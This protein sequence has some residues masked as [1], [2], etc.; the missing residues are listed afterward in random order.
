MLCKGNAFRQARRQGCITAAQQP[1]AHVLLAFCAA[2][3][4]TSRGKHRPL[5]CK[6]HLVSQ[7]L[8]NMQL[9]LG[10]LLYQWSQPWACIRA[11]QGAQHP[12]KAWMQQSPACMQVAGKR[13]G[14]KACGWQ[15]LGTAA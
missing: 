14:E 1:E 10:A 3:I 7:Q 4:F 11:K 6:L 12:E 8:H 9:Q 5:S 13:A 15:A 2:G